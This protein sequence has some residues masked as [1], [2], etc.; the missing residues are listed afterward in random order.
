MGNEYRCYFWTFRREELI[1]ESKTVTAGDIVSWVRAR[2]KGAAKEVIEHLLKRTTNYRS[3]DNNKPK[4]R[5]PDD[6]IFF[7]QGIGSV[8]PKV[9]TVASRR[10]LVRLLETSESIL[11]RR[12]MPAW[13]PMPSSRDR[14]PTPEEMEELEAKYVWRL[15]ELG[16]SLPYE[17]NLENYIVNVL[18]TVED[19][20]RLYESSGCSGIRCPTEIGTLDLWCVDR[21]GNFVVIELKRRQTPDVAIGQLARYLGWLEETY[22]DRKVRGFIICNKMRN[23]LRLAAKALRAT[24][25]EYEV[26]GLDVA[27]EPILRFRRM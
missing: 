26:S 13:D 17:E 22:P 8:D 19:G 5:F 16:G 1:P 25:F 10:T 11:F 12:Y 20:L 3:R 14:P 4:S 9:L 15:N 27:G 23:K 7:M 6:D 18:N 24:V 21:S 2:R